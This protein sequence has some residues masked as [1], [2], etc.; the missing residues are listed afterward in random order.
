MDACVASS[1][2]YGVYIDVTFRDAT[3]L[4]GFVRITAATVADGMLQIW[5]LT[6]TINNG[7]VET[8]WCYVIAGGNTW[9]CR[10]RLHYVYNLFGPLLLTIVAWHR[11]SKTPA[12]EEEWKEK[13]KKNNWFCW[14]QKIGL[15]FVRLIYPTGLF[16]CRP[17]LTRE[18]K[19][20]SPIHPFDVD[21]RSQEDFELKFFS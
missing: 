16:R 10:F 4:R 3:A 2:Q 11:T 9:S 1:S 5:L 12:K 19:V 15:S 6:M 17:E 18:Y 8:S 21:W 13:K 7:N 14:L 20:F